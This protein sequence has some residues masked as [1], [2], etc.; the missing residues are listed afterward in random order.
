MLGG[1]S[2]YL[3]HDIYNPIFRAVPVPD[4]ITVRRQLG[5][6]VNLPH[7][8]SWLSS[9][10]VDIRRIKGDFLLGHLNNLQ[11]LES[12]CAVLL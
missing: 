2:R 11:A 6:V 5:V 4:E 9:I 7:E 1:S 10:E 8:L 12:Y 3:R